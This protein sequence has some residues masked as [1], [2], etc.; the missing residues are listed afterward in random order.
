LRP[1]DCCGEPVLE[2]WELR[3]HPL[4]SEAFVGDLPRSYPA[5]VPVGELPRSRAPLQGEHT[6]QILAEWA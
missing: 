1:A 3:G 2:P 4:F 5:L 6:A